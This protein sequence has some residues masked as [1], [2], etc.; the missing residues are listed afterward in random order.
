MAPP[1]PT[2]SKDPKLPVLDPAVS[3]N[4]EVAKTRGLF[5]ELKQPLHKLN[6]RTSLTRLYLSK[7]RLLYRIR[8]TDYMTE[9]G[10]W[11]HWLIP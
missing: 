9:P 6:V 2:S 5:G 4:D 3:L 8:L 11:L 7:I 10:E 1:T